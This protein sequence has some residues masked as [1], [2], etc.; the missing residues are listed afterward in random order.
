MFIAA[1]VLGLTYVG[2]AF[3][4]LPRVNVDRPI[5]AMAGA[6]LMVLLGVLTFQEAISAIDFNTLAL[7][8]GMML[9]ITVLQ[10]AGFF[11]LL[12]A[13]AVTF[14]HT[15]RKMLLVVVVA[16]AFFSAFLVN[17]VVVLLF[18]PVI[19]RACR[20]LRANPIPYLIAEAMASNIGSTA[21]IVGSPQNMLI[22][23]ASGISFGR[24]FAHLLPVAA[25]STL[26]LIALVYLF[27]R[28]EMTAPLHPEAESPALARHGLDVATGH[29]IPAARAAILRRTLPILALTTLGFFLSSSIGVSVPLVALLGGTLAVLLS[30][31][32]P[33]DVIKNVD[34]VL[35]AFFGGLFV[36]IGGA[37]QAGVLDIFLD[38]VNL[39]P[40][41]GSM[42]SLHVL[43]A[44]VSQLVS[45]VPFTML[46]LHFLQGVPGDLLWI[47]LAAGAT[48]GGNATLIGAVANIIVVERA[49][50]EGVEVKFWEF[51]RVGIVVTSLT[52]AI[53]IGT[54]LLEYRVGWLK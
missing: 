35:L 53:S 18:T 41:V 13:R 20:L 48:L 51:T 10:R 3:T 26:V 50:R 40:S 1:L 19:I 17:D 22:G 37:R 44:V 5:A 36:V 9:L 52:L 14:A 33:S 23:V 47:S 15:P 11:T 39:S 21:T 49:A 4:R 30:G 16:T 12:A 38:R 7:L 6:L 25:S 2:V 43:S 46:M 28:K 24:F 32:R 8:L 29:A 42:V 31:L 34:W 45:N 27:Y 54:L